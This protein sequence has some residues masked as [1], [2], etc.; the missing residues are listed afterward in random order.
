MSMGN[1]YYQKMLAFPRH[2]LT[3]E[4]R[5][6]LMP[7]DGDWIFNIQ[8]DK[9]ITIKAYYFS[10]MRIRNKYNKCNIYLPFK[11][12]GQSIHVSDARAYH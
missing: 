5:I 8:T 7:Y 1:K 6:A 9:S 10:F 2:E 4:Q 3:L 11:L 12:N